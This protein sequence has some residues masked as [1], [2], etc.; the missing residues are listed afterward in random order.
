MAPGEGSAAHGAEH[1]GM[2]RG[3]EQCACARVREAPPSSTLSLPGAPVSL[4]SDA[5]LHFRLA[6]LLGLANLIPS[7]LPNTGPRM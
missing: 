5:G 2:K 4:A 1:L 7:H 6:G 3:M